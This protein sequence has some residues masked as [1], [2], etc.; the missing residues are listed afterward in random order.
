MNNLYLVLSD[1]KDGLKSRKNVRGV[2]DKMLLGDYQLRCLSE[3][4]HSFHF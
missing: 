1:T 2:V 4:L 3:S